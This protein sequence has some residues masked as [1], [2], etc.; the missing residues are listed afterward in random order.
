MD[1]YILNEI[2][3]LKSGG[4][5]SAGGVDSPYGFENS[6]ISADIDGW[7]SFWALNWRQHHDQQRWSTS[8]WDGTGFTVYGGNGAVDF[9]HAF[10]NSTGMMSNSTYPQQFD[11]MGYRHVAHSNHRTLGY[12]TQ[13]STMYSSTNYTPW[14]SNITFVRNPTD[15]DITV[16]VAGRFSNY[17][18]NGYEGYCIFAGQPNTNTYSTTSSI[19]W[20]NIVNRTSGASFYSAAGNYTFPAGKTV[21]LGAMANCWDWTSSYQARMMINDNRFDNVDVWS[22]A[23]LECDHK[24]AQTYYQWGDSTKTPSGTNDNGIVNI[25]TKCG[26]IFGDR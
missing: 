22:A 11:Q 7:A 19:N 23:G 16:S 5:P 20:T 4:L 6:E 10:W 26:Q 3:K 21:I 14:S 18:S 12:A 9:R 8:A 2:Q 25:Y 1:L 17:W 15:S 24:L 13:V